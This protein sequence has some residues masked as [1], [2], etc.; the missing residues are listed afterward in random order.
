MEP[1]PHT[2]EPSWLRR[3]PVEGPVQHP[4]A[5]HLAECH[6]LEVFEAKFQ[7]LQLQENSIKNI[8]QRLRQFFNCYSQF[9]S[10]DIQM[11][12]ISCPVGIG[13]INFF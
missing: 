8:V 5:A 12:F 2:A 3:G 11:K 6:Y 1:D 7:A 13:N 10:N 4:L 9:Q